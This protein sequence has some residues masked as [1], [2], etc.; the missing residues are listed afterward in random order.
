VSGLLTPRAAPR[1]CTLRPSSAAFDRVPFGGDRARRFCPRARGPEFLAAAGPRH[2]R[3]A[4]ELRCP[5]STVNHVVGTIAFEQ[6]PWS[7]DE[8][9]PLDNN[10]V[11][12]P[13]VVHTAGSDRSRLKSCFFTNSTTY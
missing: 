2:R 1:L 11:V 9:K 4:H 12:L 8:T 6:A 7:M 3:G 10:P 5:G 13:I